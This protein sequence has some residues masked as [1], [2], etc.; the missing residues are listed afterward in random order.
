MVMQFTKSGLLLGVMVMLSGCADWE[1]HVQSKLPTPTAAYAGREITVAEG[2]SVFEVE[3]TGKDLKISRGQAEMLHAFLDGTLKDD[4]KA[5][6]LVEQ[7]SKQ[8]PRLERQRAAN[9]ADTIRSMGWQTAAY[10]AETASAPDT[11]RVVVDHVMAVAPSCPNWE[12]HKYY[13][14]GSQAHPNFACADR[15]NLAA[16]IADPRDLIS[17]DV[18][19]A[20]TGPAA[21]HGEVRY[22]TGGVFAPVDSEVSSGG[23]SSAG[24]GTQ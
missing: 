13:T 16:M 5:V 14:Y 10:Q 3:Y 21:L 24:S 23:G 20:W 11:L 12:F 15:T 1:N 22:R 18:P 19:S 8:A 6:V 9:L 17:G 7:P 4:R 2:R